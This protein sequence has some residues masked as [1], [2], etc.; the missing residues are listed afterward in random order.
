MVLPQRTRLIF[1]RNLRVGGQC[2]HATARFATFAADANPYDFDPRTSS[3]KSG[4][5]PVKSEATAAFVAGQ[6]RFR[7]GFYVVSA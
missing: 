4:M 3:K 2:S 6:R 7:E 5:T 1:V